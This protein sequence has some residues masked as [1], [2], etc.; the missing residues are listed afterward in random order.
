MVEVNGSPVLTSK[1]I[2]RICGVSQS[3][4]SR[5]LSGHPN[6]SA[7]TREAVTLVLNETGFVPNAT[8]RAMR[9]HRTKSIGVVVST[10]V[11]QYGLEVMGHVHEHIAPYGLHLS[12]WLA[13]ED[14]NAPDA[15]QALRERSVDGLIYTTAEDRMPELKAAIDAGAPIVLMGRAMR[16]VGTDMVAGANGQ[17]GARVAEYLVLNG[18][19]RIAL[20]GG[21]AFSPGREIEDGFRRRLKRLG[22]PIDDKRAM[23]GDLFYASGEEALDKLWQQDDQP[24]A[25]FCVNDLIAY[26]VLDA[27]RVKGIRVPEDLWVIGYNDIQMSTWAAYDLTTMRQPMGQMA[28]LSVRLLMKRID[29]GPTAPPQR[30]RLDAKL[31]IRGSTGHAPMVPAGAE[32]G[33]RAS[34]TQ[35]QAF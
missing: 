30:W 4:V 20:V 6:V 31:I 28:E 15:L 19:Q 21:R 34:Y 7:K 23:Y 14:G 29:D 16:A 3:T 11:N 12:V 35:D 13:D 33:Q 17:G 10:P 1:D 26:G 32:S 5:V 8:A 2:A 22:V 24:D 18:R 25:I 27:A 9:T